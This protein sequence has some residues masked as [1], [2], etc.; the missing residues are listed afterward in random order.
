[1]KAA[2][3]NEWGTVPQYADIPAPPPPSADEVQIRVIAAGT[4]RLVRFRTTGKHF[5]ATK[6]PHIPGSDGVGRTIPDGKLVYFTTFWEKGSFAEIVNV[7][8]REVTAIPEDANPVQI[9][10]LTNPALSSWMAIKARTWNLPEKFTV[11][12]MGATTTSGAVA[13]SVARMLGAGKVIGAARDVK[14]TESLGYDGVVAL[15]SDPERTDYSV[16]ENVDLI[17][18][19]IYGPATLQLFKALKPMRPVQY[20]QIGTLAAPT[21][22]LPGDVLRA[23]DITIR[24]AAPGSYSMQTLAQEMPKMFAA[25]KGLPKQNF[26]VIPLEDVQ[27][28]WMDEKNRLVF[29]MD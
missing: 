26:K 18:D 17:L 4:H 6:L 23:K 2:L 29:T 7:A 12:I 8:K 28:Q 9:A 20:V 1:M 19:Y 3:L 22:D 24:G 16:V 25:I 27:N 11:L 15:T 5:S 21:M 13:L 14:T 10:G